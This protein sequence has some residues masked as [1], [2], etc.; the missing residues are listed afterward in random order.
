MKIWLDEYFTETKNAPEF[1]RPRKR[2]VKTDV[3]KRRATK[4][5]AAS[6]ISDSDRL[7]LKTL[8]GG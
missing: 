5:A 3:S 7:L 2:N 1:K 4:T 8:I 6:P